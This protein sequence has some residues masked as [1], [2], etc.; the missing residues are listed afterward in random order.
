M[1]YKWASLCAVTLGC[2]AFIYF[3]PQHEIPPSPCYGPQQS[4]FSGNCPWRTLLKVITPLCGQPKFSDWPLWEGG[5]KCLNSLPTLRTILRAHPSSRPASWDWLS[6]L[7]WPY[8]GPS[9]FFLCPIPLPSFHTSILIPQACPNMFSSHWALFQ[10]LLPGE[11]SNI[12]QSD[13]GG[14]SFFRSYFPLFLIFK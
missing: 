6:P 4:S 5:H 2:P 10:N 8:V 12:P 7:L 14:L 1:W 13:K 9:S 11:S 3:V